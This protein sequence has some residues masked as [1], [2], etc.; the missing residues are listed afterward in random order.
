MLDLKSV[1]KRLISEEGDKPKAAEYANCWKCNV[2]TEK[3][4]DG[5]MVGFFLNDGSLT[6]DTL[7][8]Q[9]D[10]VTICLESVNVQVLGL[11][12]DAGGGNSRLTLLLRDMIRLKEDKVW[13][14]EDYCYTQ[15]VFDPGR[16][17]YF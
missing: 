9:Y 16:S 13:L 17:V 8:R 5:H 15:S 3:G 11:C 2:F 4:M 6:G 14:N 10:Y 1:L 12:H 7:L